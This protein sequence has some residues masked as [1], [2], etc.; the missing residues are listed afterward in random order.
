MHPDLDRVIHLQQ[1]EDAAE[2]ARRT[3]ADEPARQQQLAAALESARQTL[4]HERAR[5]AANQAARRE[6]EKELS[7]HQA[8]LSKY[9]DQLMEVKTNREYQAMQKEIETA[10]HEI[11]KQED[12]LLEQ[13][14]E[15]DE[16]TLHVKQAEQ[17]YI[18]DQAANDAGRAA[19]AAELA[20]AQAAIG[21]LA[22]ERAAL[23]AGISPPIL[24]VFDRVLKHRKLSAVAPVRGG[25]CSACQI[26][27]RPQT[28]NELRRNEIIFQCESCHRI[29]Y[30]EQVPAAADPAP[31]PTE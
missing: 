2:R 29:L 7:M 3:I 1:I 30:Y 21:R 4:E 19:L 10:Q 11:R 28:V 26:L 13:M 24:A 22:G 27:I 25:R 5:L 14:I 8:R 12:R 6:I 17:A 9:R 16:V 15:F 20:E 18:D 23:A 31:H